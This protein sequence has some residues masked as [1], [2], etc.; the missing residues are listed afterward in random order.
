MR[1]FFTQANSLLGIAINASTLSLVELSFKKQQYHVLSYA[2]VSLEEGEVVDS[3][4]I[5]TE[6]MGGRIAELVARSHCN[7]K[8]AAIA[9]STNLAIT[10]HI[11]LP[12]DFDE[13]D[14]EA[15]I[16]VDAEQ[17]IPYPLAEVS[18]DFE[19]LG[20]AKEDPHLNEVLLVVSRTEYI[21]QHTDALIFSG[22]KPKIVEV[23]DQAIQRAFQLMFSSHLDYPSTIALV[24]I[25]QSR[26]TVYI[27]HQG[28]FV[29]Q[30]QQL[31]GDSQLTSAIALHYGLTGE[32][33][34]QARLDP[35]SLSNHPSLNNYDSLIF[36]PFIST[37]K[38]HLALAFEQYA[39]NETE[40]N[41]EV[42]Q[43]ILCGRGSVLPQLDKQLA[44]ELS[45]PVTL[46]NP[47]SSMTIFASIDGEQ[48]LKDAPQLMTAC[49]L[50]M[51]CRTVRH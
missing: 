18:L 17:Y 9:L 10:R 22:L 36:Q 3:Q 49:G 42:G 2:I 20:V 23:D 6:R 27:A 33:A 4:I 11:N 39:A 19:V 35:E 38:E 25:G 45:L 15:Q 24:D 40:I 5:D 29:Y 43:L 26:T 28:Q 31:F 32:E 8:Q 37:L 51:R 46:A 44:Q 30:L 1:L 14:I 34:E 47:F 50:A 41:K 16:R 7:T 21:E 12:N 13:Q 48:L